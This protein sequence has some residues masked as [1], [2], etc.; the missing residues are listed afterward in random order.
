MCQKGSLAV[1][2]YIMQICKK[3]ENQVYVIWGPPISVNKG[4]TEKKLLCCKNAKCIA[5]INPGVSVDVPPGVAFRKQ[6]SGNLCT[7]VLNGALERGR[8]YYRQAW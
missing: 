5:F 6:A 4:K 2:M 1:S 3:W 8:F 7:Y